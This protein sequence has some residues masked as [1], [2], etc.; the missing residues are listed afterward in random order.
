MMS[1]KNSEVQRYRFLQHTGDAK[2]QAFGA[3]LEEAFSHAALAL[4][5]LMWEKTSIEKRKDIHIDVE[6]RDLKQLLVNFLEEILYLLDTKMFLLASVEDLTIEGGEGC[7]SLRALFKGDKNS[8]K[9]SIFGSVKAVTYNEM[10]IT[11]DT[12]VTVQVVIDI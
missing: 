3:S 11:P 4:V 2:F 12:P 10:E 1:R 7:Y 9:Y 8:E 5:S 6:G